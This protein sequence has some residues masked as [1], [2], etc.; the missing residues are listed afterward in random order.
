MAWRALSSADGRGR[1][2]LAVSLSLT[3]PR[4]PASVRTSGVVA[5]DDVSPAED[6]RRAGIDRQAQ[7][8]P[9]LVGRALYGDTGEVGYRRRPVDETRGAVGVREGT[10]HLEEVG[11][12]VDQQHRTTKVQAK[13][14]QPP[15]EVYVATGHPGRQERKVAVKESSFRTAPSEL[16]GSERDGGGG[17]VAVPVARHRPHH[18]GLVGDRPQEAI[19]GVRRIAVPMPIIRSARVDCVRDLV[20]KIELGGGR[21]RADAKLQVH[22]RCAAL[23]PARIDRLEPDGAGGVRELRAPQKRLVIHRLDVPRGDGGALV[24]GVDAERIALPDVHGRLWDR[25]A[26]RGGLE[27]AENELERHAGLA[28]GDDFANASLVQ[29][30][31]AFDLL[32]RQRARRLRERASPPRRGD[33]TER[34]TA[35]NPNCRASVHISFRRRYAAPRLPWAADVRGA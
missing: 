7:P 24:A 34:E 22:V 28:L 32:G 17:D 31:W 1:K 26:G 29:V 2:V 21:L 10:I 27:H 30:E 23:V 33:G 13:L 19:R 35:K 20:G 16:R 6:G 12:A 9:G 5:V 15:H 25:R 4:R 11:V 14:R 3:L 8:L 18:E